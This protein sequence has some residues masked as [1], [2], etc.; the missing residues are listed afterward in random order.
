MDFRF[1]EDDDAF[2]AE[3]RAFLAKEWPGGTGDAPVDNDEEFHAERV[4]EKKLAQQ[5]WLT[6]AWPKEYGGQAATHIRQ[7]I[8]KEECAY[9]RA[10][11]G[12]GPGGQATN[13]VGP[14]VM[15]HGTDEQ[16]R[17]FLPPIAAGDTTWCQGFS[18][19]NSGSDLASVQMR[20]ER[21]GDH[22]VLNG[23]KTWTSGAAYSDWIHVIARTD[24][25]APKHKGISYF[26]VDMKSPGISYRRIHQITGRSGFYET[27]FDNVIVPRDNL[28]GEENR[29]WYVTTTTLDFE[30]SGVH[31]IGLLRRFY[32]ELLAHLSA[33][34]S[35]A[36]PDN[37][38]Q[39]A[40]RLADLQ[41]AIEVGRWLAYRV[42][43][44]QHNGQI[45]NYEASASKAFATELC[46]RFANSAVNI[47]G[48][49]G[50]LQQFS[51][52]APAEGRMSFLYLM[53]VHFTI[54]AGT[55]EIQRNI[56]AQRGL[57]LPRD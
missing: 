32:D 30:R 16:K 28:L 27:F 36:R 56:V 18:E 13:L 22:Y 7:A 2:R 37:P 49:G 26:L 46:Q 25:D 4:F 8:M 35:A 55:S 57:G 44:L 21:S 12:G 15:V 41:I 14:A 9:F 50:G 47:L 11:I 29:G 52:L 34:P 24:P 19:P 45:P 10:P 17:R 33:T 40:Y 3:M 43:W 6:L 48:L 54:S 1:S 53:T 20:A 51:Y 31:R 39:T 38:R 42:A 23:M 5:G